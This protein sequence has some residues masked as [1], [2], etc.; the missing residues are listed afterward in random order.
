M[1]T[2]KVFKHIKDYQ[3]ITTN[4]STKFKILSVDTVGP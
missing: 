1:T 2:K 3:I 4:S